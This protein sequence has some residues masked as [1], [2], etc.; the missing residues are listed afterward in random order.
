MLGESVFVE[1][2]RSM[3]LRRGGLENPPFLPMRI[4][5]EFM[6]DMFCWVRF[7]PR[8]PSRGLDMVSYTPRRFGVALARVPATPA[9][10]S[11]FVSNLSTQ[12]CFQ[13]Q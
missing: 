9:P 3:N 11:I 12:V 7:R 8:S 13:E 10:R 5:R 4:P 2:L 6:S 1:L